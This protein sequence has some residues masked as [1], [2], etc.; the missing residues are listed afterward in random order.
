M[1]RDIYNSIKVL[2][3]SLNIAYSNPPDKSIGAAHNTTES[4]W[5]IFRIHYNWGNAA[6]TKPFKPLLVGLWSCSVGFIRLHIGSMLLPVTDFKKQQL[7]LGYPY[8][9]VCFI[10]KIFKY[11]SYLGFIFLF[12]LI[13]SFWI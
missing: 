11:Y 6:N 13:F 2:P 10:H 7:V 5:R 4:M 3:L 8:F 1:V 12:F 9:N